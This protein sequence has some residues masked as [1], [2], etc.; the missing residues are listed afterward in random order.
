MAFLFVSVSSFVIR[1]IV[2]VDSAHLFVVHVCF[3]F[4]GD[5]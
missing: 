1:T 3:V 2:D 5:V 4:G